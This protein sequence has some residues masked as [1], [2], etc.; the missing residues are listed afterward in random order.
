MITPDGD[1]DITLLLFLIVVV[2]CIPAL[3][4]WLVTSR[5]YRR[6][7]MCSR[8]ERNESWMLGD[9]AG[10]ERERHS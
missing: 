4:C 5:R 3:L 10:R 9:A 7:R 6:D 8:W 1:L 2:C